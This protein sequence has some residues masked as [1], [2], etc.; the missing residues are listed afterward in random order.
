[1]NPLLTV[2]QPGASASASRMSLFCKFLGKCCISILFRKINKGSGH[3]VRSCHLQLRMPHLKSMTAAV[4]GRWE[5]R[6]PI[7]HCPLSPSTKMQMPAEDSSA[8]C[9]CSESVATD[10]VRGLLC[11]GTLCFLF[12]VC[13]THKEPIKQGTVIEAAEG[14]LGIAFL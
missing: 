9:Q 3:L 8:S 5:S 13:G 12:H 2:F 11:A 4:V 1:M 6:A 10:F 7:F 14:A